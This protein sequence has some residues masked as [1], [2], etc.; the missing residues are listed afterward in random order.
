MLG[1]IF[2]YLTLLQPGIFFHSIFLGCTGL[3]VLAAYLFLARRNWFSRP[4][5]GVGLATLL[6]I[7][8]WVAALA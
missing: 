1:A 3:A 4:L 2:G 5:Q 6:Y 8:G 7:A